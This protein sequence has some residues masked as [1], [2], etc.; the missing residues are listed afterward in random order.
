MAGSK[1]PMKTTIRRNILREEGDDYGPE[2]R[3]RFT[4][5]NGTEIEVSRAGPQA[6]PHTLNVR[7]LNGTI[8]VLPGAS[9]DIYVMTQPYTTREWAGATDR[10]TRRRTSRKKK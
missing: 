6:P 7:V 2:A 10:P 5:P 8:A 1:V 4:L 3:V 9:N